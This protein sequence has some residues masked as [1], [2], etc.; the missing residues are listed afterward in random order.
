ML[1]MIMHTRREV[2]IE[3]DCTIEEL[4]NKVCS[5]PNLIDLYYRNQLLSEDRYTS[6]YNVKNG[7]RLEARLLTMG[8]NSTGSRS[9][10]SEESLAGVASQGFTHGLICNIL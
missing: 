6:D 1:I 5:N 3:E 7:S 2:Y 8:G 9:L 4:K 10:Y